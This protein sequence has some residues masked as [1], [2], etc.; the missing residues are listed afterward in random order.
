MKRDEI[1]A[2]KELPEV[3]CDRVRLVVTQPDH[4][5]LAFLSIMPFENALMG[6]CLDQGL[7]VRL[8]IMLPLLATSNI[9]R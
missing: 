7:L 1:G 8:S 6:D 5:W 4:W 9:G 3:V 2:R